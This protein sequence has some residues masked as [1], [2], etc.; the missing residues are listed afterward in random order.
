MLRLNRYNLLFIFL[1]INCH[2]ICAQVKYDYTW[3]FGANTSLMQGAEGSIIQ[4]SDTS[5]DTF[6][7]SLP[8]KIG[9]ENISI[10]T[11]DGD[12]IAYSNACDIYN[13]DF[14]LMMNGQNINPGEVHD[15]QCPNGN[16]GGAQNSLM[17]PDPSGDGVYFYHK[18]VENI[19]FDFDLVIAGFEVLYSYIDIVENAVTK[20]NIS[21][22]ERGQHISGF[23]EAIRHAN[24][25]DWWIL[26]FS[27]WDSL[28]VTQDDSLMYVFKIDKDSIYF[29]HEQKIGNPA[30][31]DSWCGVGG[32]S[33]FSTD[34]NTF[35][36]YC[37]LSGLDLYDFNRET[38]MLS[39]YRHLNIPATY[40]VDGLCFSPNNRF[41]YV[42]NGDKLWQV[43]LEAPTLMGGLLLIE[44]EIEAGSGFTRNF[45]KMQLGPDC[46]I[47]MNST[48]QTPTLHLITH[49]D[50]KG[51]A[52][53]FV[54]GGFELPFHCQ[55]AS[56]P[57]FPHFRIDEE[58]VCNPDL[59]ASVFEFP[60]EV[61]KG[62]DIYPNPTS[63]ELTIELPDFMSGLLSVR[64]VTGQVVFTL[65]LDNNREI[66][67]DL[68]DYDSGMYL[69]EVV[70]EKGERYVERVVVVD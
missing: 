58:E 66:M 36:M 46:R 10:S 33:A 26:D 56:M 69:I 18:T 8:S 22:H 57:N 13:S 64:D 70:N 40:K 39:N 31:L 30:A 53:N 4:F 62:L 37:S 32:Q 2:S 38:A 6:Y 45:A 19:W 59:V 21:I 52:C 15:Q 65:D 54:Q 28:E 50:E 1:L 9:T 55:P 48:N 67:I 25:E 68:N 44:D 61:V 5:I 43:D 29:H 24:G 42:S 3:V 35:A 16:Y 63:G 51:E 17:L 11:I 7:H 41:V 14:N 34:G 20:K 60:V 47:Y 27:Q 12:L 49:P 23:T